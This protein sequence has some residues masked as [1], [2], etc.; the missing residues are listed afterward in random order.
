MSG[1]FDMINPQPNAIILVS[2][3]NWKE[4]RDQFMQHISQFLNTWLWGVEAAFPV[5]GLT[6]EVLLNAFFC[7]KAIVY[8]LTAFLY[9]LSWKRES[10]WYTRSWYFWDGENS[11]LEEMQTERLRSAKCRSLQI[12]SICSF[13][14]SD[15]N[16][17]LSLLLYYIERALE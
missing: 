1:L 14:L 9:S 2:N 5:E 4:E 15:F 16:F 10:A 7:C 6:F 12:Q 17:Q 8:L 11:S 13:G 3:N